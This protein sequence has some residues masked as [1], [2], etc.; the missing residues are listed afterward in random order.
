[1]LITNMHPRAVVVGKVM[2]MP[3]VNDL[4]GDALEAFK[5]ASSKPA[6]KRALEQYFKLGVLAEGRPKDAPKVDRSPSLMGFS[7]EKALEI[8]DATEDVAKLE[9]W[10]AGEKRQKVKLALAQRAETL[11]KGGES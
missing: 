6:A 9:S 11:K 8:I 1:M 10:F 4:Q 2:L 3:G 7:P 5:T